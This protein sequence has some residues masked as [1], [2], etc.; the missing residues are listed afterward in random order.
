MAAND[1]SSKL[2]ITTAADSSR[3]F[4]SVRIFA[5][6]NVRFLWLDCTVDQVGVIP[7]DLTVAIIGGFGWVPSGPVSIGVIRNGRSS[8]D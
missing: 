3:F 1:K 4:R 7:I 6:A 8:Q 5:R 2:T